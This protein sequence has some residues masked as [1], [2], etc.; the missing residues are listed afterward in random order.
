MLRAPFL[1]ACVAVACCACG[2]PTPTWGQHSASEWS[3]RLWSGDP[4]EVSDGVSALV[5]FAEKKPE[6]VV[7]ALEETFL[8]PPPAAQGA[9]FTL[10][11]DEAEAKRLGLPALAVSE[12]I[13]IVLPM[14]RSRIVALGLSPASLRATGEGDIDIVVLGPRPRSE[15]DRLRLV[16]ASRGALD[17]RVVVPDPVSPPPH[18]MRG[19]VY[20]GTEPFPAARAAEVRRWLETKAAGTEYVPADP[21]LRVAPRAGTAASHVDHFEALE[22]PQAA[23]DVLDERCV[24]NVKGYLSPAGAPFLRISV[25]PDRLA[26]ARRFTSRNA[27]LDLAVI[28]DGTV[29]ATT[30]MPPLDGATW[31]VPLG[32]P[33]AGVD[34]A[35]AWTREEA[36]LFEGGRLGRPLLAKP[37]GSAFGVDPG[38]QNP[39]SRVAATIGEPAVAMLRRVEKGSGP[40]WGKASARWALEQIGADPVV[41]G[42]GK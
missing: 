36:L 15:I 22:E 17:F 11:F 21:K 7:A 26:D 38:P 25:R 4:A 27:G 20:E 35:A 39:W 16:L 37:L 29:R 6:A 2:K 28:L 12:A 9:P 33:N 34:N 1:A 32:P 19:R 41:P 5:R 13:G 30:P 40:T 31:T 8:R 14:I 18:A 23:A 10:A 3:Q 24:L 42:A